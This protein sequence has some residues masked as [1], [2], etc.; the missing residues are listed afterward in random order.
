MLANY[1]GKSSARFSR[2]HHDAGVVRTGIGSQEY[3]DERNADLGRKAPP[4]TFESIGVR[5]P[6]PYEQATQRL[7]ET[8]QRYGQERLWLNG[9]VD[10]IKNDNNLGFTIC[11]VAFVGALVML[12]NRGVI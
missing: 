6:Q 1:S 11:I 8:R 9:V 4:V 7:E 12:R 5:K 10:G 2:Q 3:V